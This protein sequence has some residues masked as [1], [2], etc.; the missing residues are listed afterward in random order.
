MGAGHRGAI[1]ELVALHAAP[2]SADERNLQ[3]GASAAH[4]AALSGPRLLLGD[5]NLEVQLDGRQDLFTDDA[6]RDLETYGFVTRALTDVGRTAGATAE[7]D[8]R[9]DYVLASRELVG[10]AC[11]VA[12]SARASGMD[13]APLWVDLAVTPP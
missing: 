7:P 1:V 12:R 13:H 4:L 8:R 9:I 2:W 6:H 5:F 3:I 11:G 10:T